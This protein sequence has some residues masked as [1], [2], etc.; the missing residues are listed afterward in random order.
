MA[1]PSSSSTSSPAIL[2]PSKEDIQ[3]VFHAA[4]LRMTPMLD[5]GGR[6]IL[7]ERAR[8]LFL[9][10]YKRFNVPPMLL[11]KQLEANKYRDAIALILLLLPS[12]REDQL[13][14]L[15]SLD[16]LYKD[17]YTNLQWHLCHVEHT[18]A[19]HKNRKW[20]LDYFQQNFYL[21]RQSI[22]K[23]AHKLHPNWMDILP[24]SMS[25]YQ[26]SDIF[27]KTQKIL[28]P[29]A[30]HTADPTKDPAKWNKV[31]LE[32]LNKYFCE[33]EDGLIRSPYGALSMR[34]LWSVVAGELYS[35]TLPMKILL[36][37]Y[38]I[39]ETYGKPL[40]GLFIWDK[41]LPLS[42]AYNSQNW[43]DLVE[44]EQHDF[45]SNWETLLS[46]AEQSKTKYINKD[47][48]LDARTIQRLCRLFATT[49][50]QNKDRFFSDTEWENKFQLDLGY[51]KQDYEWARD[52]IDESE[53]QRVMLSLRSLPARAWYL[54]FCN[55][56][57]IIQL[58]WFG[59]MM[60]EEYNVEHGKAKGQKGRRPLQ[61]EFPRDDEKLKPWTDEELKVF[62]H[63][64]DGALKILQQTLKRSGFLMIRKIGNDVFYLSMKNLYNWAK[65]VCHHV[66]YKLRDKLAFLPLKEHWD[67]VEMMTAMEVQGHTIN[68]RNF[69]MEK[70]MG[71]LSTDDD[72]PWLNLSKYYLSTY[73]DFN[74]N[75]PEVPTVKEFHQALIFNITL[76]LPHLAVQV[77]IKRGTLTK[78]VPIP[79]TIERAAFH[80]SDEEYGPWLQKELAK[81][82]G[83]LDE[84]NRKQYR[85]AYNFITGLEFKKSY[86]H[87]L[88]NSKD[89]TWY[90][91]YALNWVSQISLFHRFLNSRYGM[92][93]GGTGVGKSS[94]VPKLLL[95]A[96]RS[97][98]GLGH[99]KV[100]CT[101]PRTNVT[102]KNAKNVA[103]Q[104][105]VPLTQT[106][107]HGKITIEDE[108]GNSGV[109]YQYSGTAL[110]INNPLQ[111]TFCTDG[112]FFPKLLQSPMMYNG[113]TT[114]A[115][116]DDAVDEDGQVYAKSKKMQREYKQYAFGKEMLSNIVVVDESHEHNRYMDL[117]EK[118]IREKMI[119]N[120]RVRFYTMSA[121]LTKFD[122]QRYRSFFR[123]IDDNDLHPFS[124]RPTYE[125]GIA[126][127]MYID[128]LINIAAPFTGTR[129][130]IHTPPKLRISHP[131]GITHPRA[132]DEIIHVVSRK[133]V[134]IS[135]QDSHQDKEDI[136]VFMPG[137]MD[138]YNCCTAINKE[139]ELHRNTIAIPYF[140][141]LEN[142]V[143]DLVSTIDKSDS[144]RKI[145]WDRTQTLDLLWNG[146]LQN[147]AK[148][149]EG[150]Q[151]RQFVIVATNIAEASITISTLKYVIDPGLANTVIYNPASGTSRKKTIMISRFNAE[152]RKGRVG[153]TM[154]GV[155]ITFYNITDLASSGG[156]AVRAYQL[157]TSNLY[158]QIFNMM[159]N[160]I[161]V[162]NYML[163]CA[164]ENGQPSAYFK[165]IYEDTSLMVEPSQ[166]PIE[167]YVSQFKTCLEV[168]HDTHCIWT[169]VICNYGLNNGQSKQTLVERVGSVSLYISKLL[170]ISLFD[171]ACEIFCF[172][173]EEFRLVRDKGGVVTNITGSNKDFI[174]KGRQTIESGQINNTQFIF[175]SPNIQASLDQLISLGIVTLDRP[176]RHEI[177]ERLKKHR[178]VRT[179]NQIELICQVTQFG[180]Q[181]KVLSNIVNEHIPSEYDQDGADLATMVGRC[182]AKRY[183][184]LEDYLR[185]QMA[186]QISQVRMLPSLTRW[187]AVTE[188]KDKKTLR[189]KRRIDTDG[190]FK[191]YAHPSS[192]HL[193]LLKITRTIQPLNE[194]IFG[195]LYT[196]NGTLSTQAM[197]EINRRWHQLLSYRNNLVT[198]RG[199]IIVTASF[200]A[201]F[202]P[203]EVRELRFIL[204]DLER[205]ST[206]GNEYAYQR[207]IARNRVS[208]FW[209]QVD[210]LYKDRHFEDHLRDFANQ[211][212]IS[213]H[214]MR[215][216]IQRL[217]AYQ[218]S[219]GL[220]QRM[221]PE[222][223]K[224]IYPQELR[225]YLEHGLDVPFLQPI[226]ANS[227]EEAI[228]RCLL[229]ENPQNIINIPEKI[230]LFPKY[231]SAR[232]DTLFNGK[233][234]TFVNPAGYCFYSGITEE[235]A[236][237]EDVKEIGVDTEVSGETAANRTEQ[238][239]DEGEEDDESEV[240]V[241]CSIL[242]KLPESMVTSM[243]VQPLFTHA[244]YYDMLK[245]PTSGAMLER[246]NQDFATYHR[247]VLQQDT[248]ELAP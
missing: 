132:M 231:I 223:L 2:V 126:D 136:L 151:Y 72:K 243:A 26:N 237:I 105:G 50:E 57:K 23:M 119:F 9:D 22:R 200:T 188:I 49:V 56:M 214:T 233:P 193:A 131:G 173:P 75:N 100:I 160:S 111:L 159:D 154:P 124:K 117:I 161:I 246:R 242:T 94:Q 166:K 62:T 182:Y 183:G 95:Y 175:F 92:I 153:R 203:Q 146:D 34:D 42:G 108:T 199:K 104:M 194:K 218:L 235:S 32:L 65:A 180:E 101:Q 221:R 13:V 168:L 5:E 59:M 140:R 201:S 74:P 236:D 164:I 226:P 156:D 232:V 137:A 143:A 66:D 85:T 228:I 169:K 40:A 83:P 52:E 177:Y 82:G 64:T 30:A 35:Q 213:F 133:V 118:E 215:A 90:M 68:A 224:Q 219:I 54:V 158:Q 60:F 41:L 39:N 21:V 77:L 155:F 190:F 149:Q 55:I 110:G 121:T 106:H 186:V 135:N 8:S 229:Y 70:I 141:G 28:Y 6:N 79:S 53:L 120:P 25:E 197:Q 241:I 73:Q 240:S 115:N 1:S 37:D 148:Y 134:E 47:M 3:N 76:L 4:L 150:K 209:E 98:E 81:K 211:K 147:K 174:I 91:L 244:D 116:E 152:Q 12:I 130:Q 185:L 99:A 29:P 20:K 170:V 162:Y 210:N 125:N 97:L 204:Q 36:Q 123:G 238:K 128:R 113:R 234:N 206:D 44:E 89:D 227:K 10:I 38:P 139:P 51:V 157:S 184:C 142:A 14:Q 196:E 86:L 167:K 191:H 245:L 61:I 96:L 202:G 144:R 27:R 178:E 192:D 103:T 19:F 198:F 220:L 239:L 189:T 163:R 67:T 179:L 107:R 230:I 78:F 87:G 11:L 138:I 187:A 114:V 165:Y 17:K 216:Y 31:R 181:I 15:P 171:V 247:K 129:F 109:G 58:N 48:Y 43:T 195:N 222:L 7:N 145:V 33:D 80:G 207:F 208:K 217:G 84:E 63:G 16:Y 69:A 24:I 46:H 18:G 248:V 205:Y 71:L 176:P 45:T 212:G 122:E 112:L 93:I 172:H 88:A 225:Q 127:R 102:I